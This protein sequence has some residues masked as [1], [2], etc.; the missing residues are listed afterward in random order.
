MPSNLGE[1]LVKLAEEG[2]QFVGKETL[3]K[4]FNSE[5]E[6]TEINGKYEEWHNKCYGLLRTVYK[7]RSDE[8]RN[9]RRASS[10]TSKIL[11]LKGLAGKESDKVNFKRNVST[12]VNVNQTQ[13]TTVH[14]EISLQILLN[15]DNSDLNNDKKN[16]AKELFKEI[17][18]EIQSKKP[19]WGKVIELLK[20]SLDYGLKIAPGMMKLVEIY[21]NAKCGA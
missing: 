11:I 8:E 10:V 2:E 1:I 3:L 6:E 7:K 4:C 17:N 18:D 14:N 19:N 21:Y 5:A 13:I 20:K 9:F 16:E 12:T 15:I